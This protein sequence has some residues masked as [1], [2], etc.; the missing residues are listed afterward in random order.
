MYRLVF[1]KEAFEDFCDWAIYNKK[2][3]RKIVDLIK[4]I[5]RTPYKGIGKPEPLKFNQ[6]G[7]WSRRIT[8]EHRLVYKVNS[9]NNILIAS[10]KGHYE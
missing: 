3:F 5:E 8:H 6:F 4:S 10:C 7:Y 2:I 9:E 1:D